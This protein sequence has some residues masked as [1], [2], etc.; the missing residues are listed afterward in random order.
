M[1]ADK[2][3][4]MM[5]EACA[6]STKCALHEKSAKKVEE[7]LNAI[8]TKLKAN[9]IPIVDGDSYG[10]VTWAHARN[11][12][13]QTLYTPV[14][15]APLFFKIAADLEKGDGALLW[16]LSSG[17]YSLFRCQCPGPKGPQAVRIIET[18]AAI[19]CGEG[20]PVDQ[21]LDDLK[22]D[23]ARM[24]QLSDFADVWPIRAACK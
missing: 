12:E 9:P 14:K 24:A 23:Y 20:D 3:L 6:S 13:F 16:Q 22:Q 5:F 8:F 11:L 10:T 18:T 15:V 2:D 4:Q 1:D 21:G 7:R 17:N 19:A